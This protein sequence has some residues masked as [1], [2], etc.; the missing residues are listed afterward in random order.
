MIY[1][2]SY[3]KDVSNILAFIDGFSEKYSL[4]IGGAT[5]MG[6]DVIKLETVARVIN[7]PDGF[8]HKDGVENSSAFKKVAHFIVWFVAERPIINPFE[9]DKLPEHLLNIENHQNAIVA[10]FIGLKAL[11]ESSITQD[12]GSKLILSNPLEL[13]SHSF[14]DIVDAVSRATPSSGFQL[15]S[16]LLEQIAYKTNGTCQYRPV[17]F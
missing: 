7:D 2:G 14:I 6:L 4:N 11:H 16:V 5:Q 9:T 3:I 8:P 13:S 12:D 1:N 10:L 15:V 17:K